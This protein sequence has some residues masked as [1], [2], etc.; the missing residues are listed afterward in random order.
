MPGLHASC[1]ASAAG[2]LT[3][4]PLG[5]PKQSGPFLALDPVRNG[6][7]AAGQLAGC[8]TDTPCVCPEPPKPVCTAVY[9]PN[10]STSPFTSRKLK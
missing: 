8:P 5:P 2:G 1:Y 7:C 4:Q 6:P 3:R 10:P 9:S